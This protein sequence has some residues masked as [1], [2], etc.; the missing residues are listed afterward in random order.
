MQLIKDILRFT[1][2]PVFLFICAISGCKSSELG[3]ADN[4][5]KLTMHIRENKDLVTVNKLKVQDAPSFATRGTNRGLENLAGGLIS[6]ATEAVITV[7]ENNKEKYEANYQFGLNDLYFYDQISN[8]S[9]FDPTG[10][11]FSGFK[12]IRT[13]KNN[14]EKEDTALA[15]SFELDTSNVSSII[16]NSFFRLKLKSFQLNYAKAKV[17]KSDP[18]VL[19]MDIEITF[20]TSYVNTHGI[21]FDSVVLGK[22]YLLIRG[23]PLDSAAK[24]YN[25]YYKDM[26]GKLLLG[27]SFIVPRSFGYHKEAD[28]EI[29]SGYSQGLYS[30]AV[31][32]RESSKPN[33]VNRMIM[34]NGPLLLSSGSEDL[35]SSITK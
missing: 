18:K 16:N 21:I 2:V 3:S 5:E 1:K 19:N 33:F 20:L 27:K 14:D 4:D 17:G 10:L 12:L 15:M 22:F 25:K 29:K 11:Q 23:A 9:P 6:L 30:I 34:E 28:G 31:K 26:A 8:E 35:K 24:N 13:F 32:V 7:I